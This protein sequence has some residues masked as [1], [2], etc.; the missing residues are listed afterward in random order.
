MQQS[1]LMSGWGAQPDNSQSVES[2]P[3]AEMLKA[4][5]EGADLARQQSIYR[6]QTQ[7]NA[8]VDEQKQKAELAEKVKND[9]IEKVEQVGELHRLQNIQTMIEQEA[10]ID[11]QRLLKK[12]LK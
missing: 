10:F 4:Q 11:N 12:E 9:V 1:A 8:A 6:A 3:L 5:E 2:D 7:V